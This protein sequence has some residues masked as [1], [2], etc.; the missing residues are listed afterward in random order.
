MN[1]KIQRNVEKEA[2]GFDK[3]YQIRWLLNAIYNR[4]KALWNL[5]KYVIIDKM[6][7]CCKGTYHSIRQ[8]M[9]N[10]LEKWGLKVWCLAYLTLKYVWDFEVHCK[11]ENI[12]LVAIDNRFSA[13][14]VC[15][16]D[17]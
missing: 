12:L 13:H 10:N 1:S 8:H 7:I 15:C 14:V 4:C 3:L 16:G 6:M 9:P 11:K 17:G 2:L 5:G